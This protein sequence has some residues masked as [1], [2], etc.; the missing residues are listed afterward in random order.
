MAELARTDEE[1]QQQISEALTTARLGQSRWRGMSYE[2]GVV[3][4]LEWVTGDEDEAP[5]ED[6]E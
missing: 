5:M 3:A 2:Q 6:G 1:I 4:A